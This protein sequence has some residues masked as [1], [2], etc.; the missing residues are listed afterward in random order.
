MNKQEI[1]NQNSGLKSLA[2][3]E[4]AQ[5]LTF[6]THIKKVKPLRSESYVPR[7]TGLSCIPLG[8]ALI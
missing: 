5:R 7:T 1:K 8:K 2:H 3:Y 6:S 4:A